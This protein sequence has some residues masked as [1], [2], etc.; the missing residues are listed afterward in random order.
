MDESASG[1]DPAKSDVGLHQQRGVSL[2]SL[3][4]A[5]LILGLLYVG[6]D[7]L[8][9]SGNPLLESTETAMA[10]GKDVACRLN[11]LE[12]ERS[13]MT[14]TLS[15]PGREPTLQLL[16]DEQIHVP[17]CPEGGKLSLVGRQVRC[18]LHGPFSE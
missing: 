18:S 3:V 16:R 11:R 6:F 7:S 15:H 14:W 4:A 17:P 5:L 8:S 9:R 13:I 10:Q 2:V 12:I 1:V